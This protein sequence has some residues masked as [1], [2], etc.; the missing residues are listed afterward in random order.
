MVGG[1]VLL[2]NLVLVLAGPELLIGFLR[3][4]ERI[5][6]VYLER[7]LDAVLE[8]VRQ[9]LEA[10]DLLA[11]DI[12]ALLLS[13]EALGRAHR[14]HGRALSGEEMR[15][16]RDDGVLLVELQR[17]DVG[18]AELVEEV[19][20][21]AEEADVSPD[22]LTAGKT[23]DGLITDGL[24]DRRGEVLLCRTLVDQRL[25]ISLCEDAAAGRDR[26]NRLIVLCVLIEAGGV[27][28]QKIRHLINEG[29]G[30]AGAD[31]VHPLLD[32]SIFKINDLGVLTAELDRDVCLRAASLNRGGDGDDLLYERDSEMRR[33]RQS[34]RTGD[35][36]RDLEIAELLIGLP[37]QSA[38]C[39]LDFCVMTLIVGEKKIV[40]LVENRN[41]YGCR[42]DINAKRICMFTHVLSFSVVCYFLFISSNQRIKRI[43]RLIELIDKQHIRETV[44]M[45]SCGFGRRS[46]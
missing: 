38:G 1:E 43:I 19:Q 12:G 44:P 6:A 13:R 36:R 21:T 25:D 15:I 31:A 18:G 37:D 41:L 14:V 39:G 30:A 7:K 10:C 29:A 32:V 40:V 22:R 16:L 11:G 20:R 24:E 9:V 4:E 45:R 26:I 23:G 3:R 5:E 35:G 27:C 33:K 46:I 2:R 34:A 8:A 28:L 42:T 17:A